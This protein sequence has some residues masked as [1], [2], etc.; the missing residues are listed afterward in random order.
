LRLVQNLDNIQLEDIETHGG[1]AV[2]LAKLKQLGFQVP[3]AV[4]ISAEAFVQMTKKNQS[5]RAFLRKVNETDDFEEILEISGRIQEII[6]NYEFPKDLVSD[7][8]KNLNSL[9]RS[10]YGF[11]VRSSA[12]IEDRSDI[13]FA[14]QAESYLCVKTEADIVESVKNVWRS[15]FSDRAL[16]YLKTKDIPIT[17][18][19]MAVLVQEMIPAEISGVMFT[20]NVVTNNIDEMLINSTWGLGDL[21]VSGQVVPDT[22]ILTKR[23]LKVIQ[24]NLGDKE[25]TSEP[26][27]HPLTITDTPKENRSVYSLEPNTLLDIAE[28]GMKIES[29]MESPQD[30]EWCIR[31]DG[32]LVILQSRPITTLSVPSSHEEKSQE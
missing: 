14:G 31:P 21:L 1:K 5:L 13:S 29:G 17:Q 4:S 12:T 18:V 3:S 8:S 7:I 9:E 19:K 10:E 6:Y 2:N 30:I 22:Y 28:V 11:A 20:A 25:F 15:A 16:I 27:M 26:H 32:G 24:Q 23:P